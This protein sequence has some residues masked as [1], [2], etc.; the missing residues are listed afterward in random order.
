MNRMRW[1]KTINP[2]LFILVLWQAVTGLGHNFLPEEVF[3]KI[4]VAG[5]LLL[6]TFVVIHLIFNWRWVKANY[7]GKG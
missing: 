7:F 5:G 2:I 4:H 1:L 6:M 3:E